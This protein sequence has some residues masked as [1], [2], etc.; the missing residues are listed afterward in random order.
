MSFFDY[1]EKEVLF[2]DVIIDT[3]KKNNGKIVGMSQQT[4]KLRVCCESSHQFE[5]SPIEIDKGEWCKE[6]TL[7]REFCEKILIKIFKQLEITKFSYNVTS[8][9]F[10]LPFLFSFDVGNRT[11]LIDV[12]WCDIDGFIEESKDTLSQLKREN[13]T[14]IKILSSF[15]SNFS[16]VRRFIY[17]CIT[18]SRENVIPNNKYFVCSHPE[19][20]FTDEVVFSS[21]EGGV[22]IEEDFVLE[23]DKYATHLLEKP[24]LGKKFVHYSRIISKVLKGLDRLRSVVGYITTLKPNTM[25]KRIDE[26]CVENEVFVGKYYIDLLPEN[27]S[28]KSKKAL[29]SLL[30]ET[31]GGECVIFDGLYSI[32]PKIDVCLKFLTKLKGK[33]IAFKILESRG[34][35]TSDDFY[36][37]TSFDKEDV[38][39]RIDVEAKKKKIAQFGYSLS[40]TGEIVE[41][42]EEYTIISHIRMKVEESKEDGK[43]RYSLRG[44]CKYLNSLEYRARDQKMWYPPFVKRV[45]EQNY[46]E[47]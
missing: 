14:I 30:N 34:I 39:E 21:T 3:I 38:K 41:N 23:K 46:I 9:E 47:L 25:E 24:T 15:F 7:S 26:W 16:E 13:F 33:G 42:K 36:D 20:Y 37:I 17:E 18:F 11:F 40:E 19:K 43:E 22:S 31:K 28:L 5:I 45:L 35:V 27:S 2:K 8:P 1:S 32:H 6:C 10:G 12:D 44:L 4:Q 29:L